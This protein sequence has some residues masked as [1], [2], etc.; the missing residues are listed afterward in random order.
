MYWFTLL[1]F[2][3]LWFHDM[4]TLVIVICTV[5]AAVPALFLFT[6]TLAALL[7]ARQFPQSNVHKKIAI[8]VP[9]HNESL[10]IEETLQVLQQQ[11]Y[12]EDQFEIVVIADNCTDDTAAK[13]GKIGARVIERNSNPGK[14]QA[15]YE[16]FGMLMEESW[17]AFLII[18]ADSHLSTNALTELNHQLCSGIDV[19]Q[20]RY[21]VLNPTESIRTKAMEL[22]TASYNG[23]RHRG[24]DT[25]GIS[26]GINGNGF[27]LTRQTLVDV[28]YLAHSI[29][30]DLE[31]HL[32]LLN[33]GYK[34]SFNDRVVVKA[35]MPVGD[36]GA[37]V[38]RVRWERGRA[39]MIKD[40]APNLFKQVFSRP[41]VAFDGLLSVLMPPVSMVTILL[42]P[43]ILAGSVL[44]K[45]L[46]VILFLM[47][48]FHYFVAAW[49]YASL[50]R[51]ARLMLY[52]PWYVLW[53]TW[54]VI[55]SGFVERQ[56]AW[57]RTDR[58]ESKPLDA[59]KLDTD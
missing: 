56:L 46:C 54:I 42:A 31:Y 2:N 1:G 37:E 53:K 6:L 4:L 25:L 41:K 55:K 28:P 5:I 52:I 15:L 34:V 18:D 30:E 27:C 22:S 47:L 58:H 48:V 13:A 20:V 33:A 29:V 38:Q 16:T 43:G 59:K 19:I 45:S 23:L 51:F 49:R 12:P 8:V 10:L 9:A 7:P 14:G 50:K 35:Q 57:V 17:D 26:I 39:M 44:L 3:M 32:L 11:D 24:S 40:Y 21:G 36:R